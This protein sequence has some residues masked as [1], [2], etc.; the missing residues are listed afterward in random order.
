M[1]NKKK[2]CQNTMPIIPSQ[3]QPNT[4]QLEVMTFAPFLVCD[5][6]HGVTL[7]SE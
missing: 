6:M 2:V 4:I 1:P 7:V 5:T 3:L